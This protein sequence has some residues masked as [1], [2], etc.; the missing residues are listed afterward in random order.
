MDTVMNI[1]LL[2]LLGFTF[3][4]IILLLATVGVYRWRRII[5]GSVPISKFVSGDDLGDEWYGRAMRAHANCIENLP[6]FTALIV[7]A[8][9]QDMRSTMF[10]GMAVLT[11]AAR[12]AQSLVHVCFIQTNRAVSFRFLFYLIQVLA[13]LAMTALLASG[14]WGRPMP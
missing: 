9:L 14:F 1:P 11:L 4:T 8:G 12:I 7:A 5:A 6:V 3:W 2:S 10:D 13:F